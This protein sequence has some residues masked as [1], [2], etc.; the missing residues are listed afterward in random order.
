MFGE[1]LRQRPA[2]GSKLGEVNGHP[3]HAGMPQRFDENRVRSQRRQRSN[4]LVEFKVRLGFR[5]TTRIAR[6]RA[7]CD[8]NE[9]FDDAIVPSNECPFQSPV[10][11]PE[12]LRLK[13]PL[14]QRRDAFASD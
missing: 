3:R 6:N 7:A 5:F 1:S 10:A 4:R 8:R 11:N 13:F 14:D 12:M 2:V 9:P